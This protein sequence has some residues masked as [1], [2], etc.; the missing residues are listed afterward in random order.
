MKKIIRRF[1][2]KVEANR[3]KDD[4]LKLRIPG[5]TAQTFLRCGKYVCMVATTEAMSEELYRNLLGG[6]KNLAEGAR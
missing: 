4:V 2:N 6:H 5:L 1:T 3:Y